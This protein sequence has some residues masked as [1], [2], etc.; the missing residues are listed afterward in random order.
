MNFK[1]FCEMLDEDKDV[2]V[3]DNDAIKHNSVNFYDFETA[4][5]DPRKG[6]P[7]G[8]AKD[9]ADREKP[10][11][12]RFKQ[13]G[14]WFSYLKGVLSTLSVPVVGHK[15]NPDGTIIVF[16]DVTWLS[17]KGFEV[18]EEGEI[19]KKFNEWLSEKLDGDIQ[20]EDV[21]FYA[22]FIK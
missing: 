14:R 3:I 18:D 10:L 5:D 15:I 12:D 19:D 7:E 6:E 4:K 13:Q 21:S 8:V 2:A 9:N 16:V 1:K 11:S 22:D 17:N 20:L